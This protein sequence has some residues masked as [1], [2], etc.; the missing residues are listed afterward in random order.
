MQNRLD[1]KHRLQHNG[2]AHQVIIALGVV[3]VV[4]GVFGI[5]RL[6]TDLTY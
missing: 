4:S 6:I 2:N 1:Y 3:F 5:V